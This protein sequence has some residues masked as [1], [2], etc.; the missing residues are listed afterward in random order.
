[1]IKL[2][3]I[4]LFG[5]LSGAVAAQTVSAERKIE[6]RKIIEADTKKGCEEFLSQFMNS[7]KPDATEKDRHLARLGIKEACY[8]K[9]YTQYRC[10]LANMPSLTK[11]TEC[12]EKANSEQITAFKLVTDYGATI[13]RRSAECEMKS[14]LFEAEIE[15]SPYPFLEDDKEQ[16]RLYDFARMVECLRR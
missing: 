15:F 3:A 2:A 5:V 6:L 8:N 7:A 4:L 9:T 10:V 16:P 14:R 1:M 12:I 13:A 11:A